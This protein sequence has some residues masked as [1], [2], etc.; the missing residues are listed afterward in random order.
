MRVKF[1]RY[2]IKKS[3]RC[4]NGPIIFICQL[5][6]SNKLD[7][8]HFGSVAAT[9]SQL[10]DAGV[11]ALASIVLGRDFAE[12][13]LN[14]GVGSLLGALGILAL[15]LL[16]LLGQGSVVQISHHLP[17][18]ME[19]GR[20][21]VGLFNLDYLLLLVAGFLLYGNGVLVFAYACFSPA[22]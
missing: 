2:Y 17:A 8:C 12:Q 9:G 3:G 22:D 5:T 13:L 15:A 16:V 4:V 20:H 18:G 7:N 6:L 1:Y 14:H 10:V 11:A 21:V 19:L